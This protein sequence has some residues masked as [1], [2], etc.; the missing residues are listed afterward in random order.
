MHFPP[1]LSAIRHRLPGRWH[2]QHLL[3]AMLALSALFATE[4]S[5]GMRAVLSNHSDGASPFDAQDG[6]G[7]DSNAHNGIVRSFDRFQYRLSLQ[8]EQTEQALRV[9]LT[10]PPATAGQAPV[11]W[12]YLP[13]FCER[14]PGG[15]DSGLSDD[16]RTLSCQ[17]G[18]VAAGQTTTH[19]LEAQVTR[20]ARHGDRIAPPTVQIVP[21]NGSPPQAVPIQA[22]ALTVSAA[23]FY[24]VR[25]HLPTRNGSA[26]A[27]TSGPNREDGLYH[28]IMLG[29]LV[30]NPHHGGLIGTEQLDARHPVEIEVDT[31]GFPPSVRL[32]DWR[33][34]AGQPANDLPT[35]SFR[36]GCGSPNNGRPSRWVGNMIHEPYVQDHGPRASNRNTSVANGGDCQTLSADR[37]HV[38]VSITG[39][40]TSL[41]HVPTEKSSTPGG[42]IPRGE[43]WV[44]NKTL[45][46]WTPLSDY[47]DNVEIEHLLRVSQV[48][49][50]SVTGQPL[51]IDPGH[52]GSLRYV[53]AK[54]ASSATS[55]VFV[56]DASQPPPK[57]T[58]ADPSA[59]ASVVNQMRPGQTVGVDLDYFNNGTAAQDDA[60]LCEI[61]DRTAFEIGPRFSARLTGQ[62]HGGSIQY[63][64]RNAASPH[65]TSTDS[66]P[67]E[68]D[69]PGLRA[70]EGQS[71]YS[72]ARCDGPDISWFSQAQHAQGSN[73][74]VYVR[75]FL[76]QLKPNHRFG[77]QIRGLILRDTWA[78]DIQV[79]TPA[80][81][82]SRRQG[83]PIAAN[84]IIRGRAEIG[85]TTLP[86]TGRLAAH[87]DHLRVINT[88][89]VSRLT[90][91]WV[92]PD[93]AVN[94]T[95]VP[96]GT[97]L[98]HRLQGRYSSTMLP[99]PGTVTIHTMLP[100]GLQYVNGS[101][102]LD[103][104]PAEPRII[105]GTHDSAQTT[106]LWTLSSRTPFLGAN[107]KN[108]ALLPPIEFESRVGQHVRNGSLLRSLA[109][110]SGGPHDTEADCTPDPI[111]LADD[112]CAKASAVTVRTLTPSGFV[113]EHQ[114]PQPRIDAGDAFETQIRFQA[115]GVAVHATDLPEVIQILPFVG[116][117]EDNPATGFQ[118]RQPA[119]RFT[120]GALR[121]TGV[122][123]PAN[124]PAAEV[125]YTRHPA[126]E[127]HPDPRH[128]SNRLPDGSTRW[129]LAHQFG[130]AGCPASLADSTA[131]R[132]RPAL[133]LLP[134][135]QPY[136]IRL[137]WQTDP[138]LAAHGSRFATHV[139]A[140]PSQP[141]SPL[142]FV[143][144]VGTQVVEV[145]FQPAALSGRSFIDLQQDNRLDA[146]DTPISG[147]CI[148]LTGQ[149]H[150]G[151]PL[152]YS[153]LTDAQGH[154]GFVTGAPDRIHPGHGCTGTPLPDF[155]GLLAGHYTLSR[156]ANTAG[157][158][159]QP[160]KLSPGTAGG[161]AETQ[162]IEDIV[163]TA[164]TAAH[165]YHFTESMVPP[166]LTLRAT[167]MNRHGG[168]AT[169]AHVRLRLMP[170]DAPGQPPI[171]DGTGDGQ[172]LTA[173]PVPA[174]RYHLSHEAPPGYQT[175]TWQCR[176]N[177]QN[178][179]GDSLHLSHGDKASCSLVVEDQPARLSLVSTLDIRHGRQARP[180]DF[181]LQA[182][183]LGHDEPLLSGASGAP[184]VTG[185]ALPAGRYQL[186][187]LPVAHFQP[188]PWQCEIRRADGRTESPS[189]PE[190]TISLGHGDVGT[191][192]TSHTDAP[193]RVALDGVM[194]EEADG[195]THPAPE[196]D[197][198]VLQLIPVDAPAQRIRLRPGEAVSEG[199]RPDREYE[200][201]VPVRR[202]YH[203][204]LM[205]HGA[206]NRP[207]ALPGNRLRLTENLG[208]RISFKRIPAEMQLTQTVSGSIRP[209]PGSPQE[210]DIDYRIEV[211]HQGGADGYYDL[212]TQPG[213]DED[214]RIV[215]VQ[216]RRDDQPIGITT[217]PAVEGRPRWRLASR[218][219]LGIDGQ[220]VYLLRVRVRVPPGSNTANDRCEGGRPGHGLAHMARL[221][222]HQL[223]GPAADRAADA[224]HLIEASACADTPVPHYR[225]ALRLKKSSTTRSADIGDWLSYRLH[226]RNL[227]DGPARSPVVID[228]LPPGFRLDTASVRVQGARLLRVTRTAQNQFGIELDRIGQAGSQD[229]GRQDQARPST[230]GQVT[231]PRQGEVVIS[232]RVRVGTGA[233]EGD[234][235]N[236]AQ[237]NCLPSP[238]S[239][240]AEACSNESRWQVQVRAGIFSEETCLAGQVY[241]DCNGNAIKDVNEPG[242]PGVRLYLQN[243]TW[244]VTDAHGKYSHCGLR[245]RTHVL[246]IDP[247][248]LPRRSRLVTS[249][250]QS[251]GDAQSLFIDA[252]KGM[253]HRADFIEGSCS[254]TVIEQVRARQAQGSNTSVQHK[255]GQRGQTGQAF[256]SKTGV[257]ERA[258][259]TGNDAPPA[260]DHSRPP[261][262]HITPPS[263]QGR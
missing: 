247:R 91:T 224:G 219:P 153:T 118:A 216:A 240:T 154:F 81:Q 169:P 101:A 36:D 222:V 100:A 218:H 112:G 116:D 31:S 105:P 84:T 82:G 97:T 213:F 43:Y 73:G 69:P 107:T 257:M 252:K 236:R 80:G 189:M 166:Q 151:H 168:T 45:V 214:A 127:I 41:A 134:P 256:D 52:D 19:Y 202:G 230:P 109:T 17:L 11:A 22:Q 32:D 149:S 197:A 212:V 59:G 121:L 96:A 170:A 140:G 255:T 179:Q 74:L 231:A 144:S 50:R 191:C 10:L 2:R 48:S 88:Q 108:E 39:I 104:Q 86:D 15:Q 220:D 99:T 205:C 102:T 228:Q 186:L 178:R 111:T 155:V 75:G 21:A 182:R 123:P 192:R 253:L 190:P 51:Q 158:H 244:M 3:G 79:E 56:P 251:A 139:N 175:G 7:L 200:L 208:C 34:A 243:G 147:Q 135:D 206:D 138:A 42:P 195:T 185:V 132:I 66:A 35:G 8:P 18:T 63:G 217:L 173:R 207:L 124:D 23:P 225:A 261:G 49:G 211:S 61:I 16:R 183:P 125:L 241:V 27:P 28:R 103:G 180:E 85:S 209:V 71:A 181:I 210:H 70:S 177:D 115:N 141:A 44:A 226:I 137:Q 38:R 92:S 122:Q 20:G 6:P 223:G 201:L 4:A 174:G 30:R 194:V 227:G 76:P 106:L 14:G 172:S 196:A 78:A 67:S 161:R 157:E 47:P 37:H 58:Q 239:Q 46:L 136:D 94:Q 229:A 145:S 60:Y 152:R 129:C 156:P 215:S 93:S 258:Y 114:A 259:V 235:I 248:T 12:A 146:E 83:T 117:G 148:D 131:V 33:H 128:A 221:S 1:V 142:P 130:S 171:L 55:R 72:R 250:A 65:F 29:L 204:R 159:R 188:G 167:V 126:R 89:T 110:I 113:L 260:I 9:V 150:N 187:S 198:M 184:G 245:P 203:S 90:H 160:G 162:R 77:L 176:I 263:L 254:N 68:Y 163:L 164:G 13:T 98:R 25:L 26:A 233:M 262:H 62:S 53:R 249:S 64:V 165:G 199:L 234:G 40:D 238:D 232:Y 5:A 237:V 246:K 133:P 24:D 120:P 193:L 143:R 242:I 57:A 119:S 54:R 87:R 95:P